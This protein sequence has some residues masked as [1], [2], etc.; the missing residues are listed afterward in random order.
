MPFFII[1]FD[2]QMTF[3]FAFIHYLWMLNNFYREKLRE[4]RIKKKRPKKLQLPLLERFRLAPAQIVLLSFFFIVMLGTFVLSLPM[5]QKTNETMSFIDT[6][7]MATSATCV[8][9]LSV[10]AIDQQFTLIGQV[11]I[12]LLIQVGGLGYMTLYS[13]LMI[14]LGKSFGYKDKLMMQDLLEISSISD[15]FSMITGIIK[16]T[17]LIEII[18]T[19]FLSYGF[20]QEGLDFGNAIY[21]GFFHSISAFCNAGFSLMSQSLVGVETN[22]WITGTISILIVLGGMGFIVLKEIESTATRLSSYRW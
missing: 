22:Y 20:I 21:Y 4:R 15:L 14:L 1:S 6:L 3:Y 13:S 7:F 18:G 17:F 19:V 11:I 8:T 5:S 2:T 16:Y 10:V 9:G 12:L